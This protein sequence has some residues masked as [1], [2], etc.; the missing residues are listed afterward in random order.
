M[1]TFLYILFLCCLPVCSFA[2]MIQDIE[3]SDLIPR[4]Y[5]DADPV[6]SLTEEERQQVEW[7]IYLRQNP[8]SK[9][10]KRNQAFLDEMTAA[11]PQLE[12]K[13]IDV[14]KIIAGRQMRKTALNEE[15]NG[16]RVR[17]GGYLLPLEQT[18]KEIREF[19]LVPYVGACIHVP[20]P[21]PNQIVHGISEKPITYAMDD[22]FKPVAATGRLRAKSGRKNLFLR[23]GASDVEIGYVMEVEAVE[24]YTKP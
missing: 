5:Q 17:L 11:L 7:N 22:M 9:I 15:L 1:K 6:A 2:E 12:K 10:D 24:K 3:W 13:G 23:D 20:P 21:S 18:G 8:E 14:D 16:K 19:L 4:Q